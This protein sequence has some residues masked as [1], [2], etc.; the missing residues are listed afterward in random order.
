[1]RQAII[2]ELLLRKEEEYESL[3]NTQLE[4]L[5]IMVHDSAEPFNSLEEGQIDET[6]ERVESRSDAVDA[7]RGELDILKAMNYDETFD[8]VRMGA[9]IETNQG[10]FF[11]AVPATQFEVEGKTYKGI[12]TRSPLYEALQG[13]GRGDS[14]DLNGNRFIIDEIW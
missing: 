14:V 13:R 11:V 10:N 6:Q 5:E 2:N 4:E 9:V 8:Q 3:M 12:S 7:L 1:M